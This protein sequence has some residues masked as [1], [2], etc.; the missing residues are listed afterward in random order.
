MLTDVVLITTGAQIVDVVLSVNVEFMLCPTTAMD[1]IFPNL[2]QWLLVPSYR[3][4]LTIMV[5]IVGTIMTALYI[6][7]AKVL[8]PLY[9]GSAKS[10][11][12]HA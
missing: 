6:F 5:C 12:K 9:H 10:T 11:K 8:R 3:T 2:P 7:A 1:V 4:T